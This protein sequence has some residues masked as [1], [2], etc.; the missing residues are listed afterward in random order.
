MTQVIRWIV[1]LAGVLFVAAG[2]RW[3]VDPAGAAGTVGMVLQT[4][5]GLSSQIGDMTSFF[6]TVGST[7]L[8]GAFTGRR[9]WFYPPMLLLGVAA[10]ARTLAWAAHGAPLAIALIAV[11]IG[12]VLLLWYAAGRLAA[13]V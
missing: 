13:D 11:E 5:V 10:V 3:M 9:L 8:L 6:V 12:T 2:L 4:G 7:V 1:G